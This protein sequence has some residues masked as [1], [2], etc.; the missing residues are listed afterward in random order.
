MATSTPTDWQIKKNALAA[1]GAI[2]TICLEVS[3]LTTRKIFMVI[4]WQR[5]YSIQDPIEKLDLMIFM[6][7]RDVSGD[8][9]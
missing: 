7:S 8:R 1:L 2:K 4:A 6:K 5:N 3:S 9:H